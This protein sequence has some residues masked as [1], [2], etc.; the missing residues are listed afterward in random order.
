MPDDINIVFCI[1]QPEVGKKRAVE[2]ALKTPISDKK[3]KVATPSGALLMLLLLA[4]G[5]SVWP[6]DVNFQ[7]ELY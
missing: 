1:L 5:I 4:L 6:S 7:S 2:N 3:A